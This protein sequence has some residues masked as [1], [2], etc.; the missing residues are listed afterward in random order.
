MTNPWDRVFGVK[1]R[2]N[3]GAGADHAEEM[4]ALED[5]ERDRAVSAA[6]RREAL[7][8]DTAYW[9][10]LMWVTWCGYL[11]AWSEKHWA[12]MTILWFMMVL[13]TLEIIPAPGAGSQ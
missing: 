4:M 11:G 6:K 3:G 13:L 2:G 5:A 1:W 10:L 9:I 12:I 8:S 7:M